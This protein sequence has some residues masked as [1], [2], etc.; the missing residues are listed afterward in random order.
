M[1]EG[2]LPLRR[3]PPEE[4]RRSSSAGRAF[5]VL[6]LGL[7]ISLL[8]NAPGVHKRAYNQP[9]GWERTV[10]IAFTG[11]LATLSHDLYLDRARVGVQRLAGRSGDDRID[12]DLGIAQATPV[13]LPSQ[14]PA[15][16]RA[17]TPEDELRLWV[18]GD[19]L[20]VVPGYAIVRAT[21]ASAALRSVGGVDGRI[22]TGLTRPDI[23]NWFDEIRGRV[24]EL[25]PGAVI[26]SFGAN[27]DKRYMTGVPDDVEIE[28][29]G[30]EAWM[31]EY[32]RR[33]GGIFDT[34]NRAGAYAIWIGLP[35]T[36]DPEQTRRFD[37]INAAVAAEALKRPGAATYLDTYRLFAGDD[38]QY[39]EYLQTSRGRFV[40]VR[41]DDGVHFEPAGGD[42][43]AR[44]VLRTLNQ[45]YDLTSWRT[46]KPG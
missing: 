41:A 14:P 5:V 31:K 22:A 43:I 46:T 33:V 42:I 18:V 37:V 8:L 6:V 28:A 4:R 26:L 38:A 34:I 1:T 19:S 21:G 27:D 7:G 12:V 2:E 10:A 13:P 30:D 20:V 24:R 17:F 40:K 25:K 11:P 16:K 44:E 15:A 32:R 3:P 39:A 29:F 23:F 45:V 9:D 36:R 35:Q